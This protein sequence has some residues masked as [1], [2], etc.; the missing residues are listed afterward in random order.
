MAITINGDSPNLTSATLTTP[1]LTSPTI[2]G[3]VVSTMA[4]SV[5]TSRTSVSSAAVYT[6][7]ISGTT[8]TV[9]AVTSPARFGNLQ[10]GLNNKVDIFE[11]KNSNNSEKINAGFF[12]LDREIF[13]YIDGDETSFEH[14][15]LK[16]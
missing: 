5:I 1:T 3:A 15:T 2:T 7:S 9:T 16:K 12:V 14:N 10:I 8:M 11:E 6:A 4:S 13:N